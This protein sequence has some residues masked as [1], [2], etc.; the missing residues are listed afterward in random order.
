MFLKYGSW[1]PLEIKNSGNIEIFKTKKFE[2]GS[3]KIVTVI[4]V[5]PV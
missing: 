5:R 3:L 2:I 1:F 4:Y